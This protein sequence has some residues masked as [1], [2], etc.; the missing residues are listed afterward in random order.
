MSSL[1]AFLSQNVAIADNEKYV[2]S[3]RFR[4]EKSNEAMHW[5]LCAVSS[6]VD[7]ELRANST[8]KVLI[9]G[10]KNQYTME[11]DFNK[12]LC[13]LAVKCIVFPNLNDAELQNSWGVM[14]AESLLL[15]MLKP[16]EYQ[17]LLTRLQSLNGF[18]ES[19]DDLVDTVKN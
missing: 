5:E 1:K 9:P 13:K 16:G 4:D 3:K 8:R 12:Y 15:K 2:V 17:D 14:D 18:N 11:T 19:M 10:K 6:E 7:E